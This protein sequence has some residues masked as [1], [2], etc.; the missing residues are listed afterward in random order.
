[1]ASTVIL[2]T[3]LATIFLFVIIFYL[4]GGGSD[5]LKDALSMTASFFG[6]I[7]TLVAAY[8]ATQLFNDWRE[9]H[10]KMI[11]ANEAKAAFKKLSNSFLL[12]VT[13]QHTVKRLLGQNTTFSIQKVKVSF[14]PLVDFNHEITVDLKY[15]EDLAQLSKIT[16]LIHEYNSCIRK[17][18]DYIDRFYSN[19]NNQN[20]SQLFIDNCVDFTREMTPIAHSIKDVLIDY[21]L[22]REA[23]LKEPSHISPHS[24][25]T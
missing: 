13:Y 19:P 9:Q 18:I 5:A 20:I 8:V 14:K 10:N 22:V 6:G 1:M 16:P 21:I 7:T 3:T 17:H 25:T 12:L 15:F 4:Y 23:L 24:H 11:L 2:A